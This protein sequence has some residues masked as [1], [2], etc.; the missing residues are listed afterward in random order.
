MPALNAL[1]DDFLAAL[2]SERNYSPHTV[3]AY[4]CDLEQ[5]ALWLERQALAFDAIGHRDMRHYLAELNRAGYARSTMNR[6]LSAIKAFYAWLTDE[7]VLDANP[8]SVVQGAKQPH[9]LPATLRPEDLDNLLVDHGDTPSEIRDFTI[10]E[11][12]YASGARISEVAG[13]TLKSIDFDAGS[14]RVL[15]KGSK[16]RV[17]P[18]YPH[19]LVLIRDYIRDVRPLLLAKAKAKADVAPT[20]ALFIGNSGKPLSADSLRKMFK[21]HMALIGGD[22]GLGPH[23]MRHTFAT[24]LLEGGADIRSVQ[25][26]LGH[27][28][29][30][31]T[32]IYTHI[33]IGHLKETHRK[34]HPRSQ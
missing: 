23:A 32:Q 7:N 34:A 16:E 15:G 21:R 28:S 13:L 33:S 17:I 1:I 20:Q 8:T 12:L 18:L 6:H 22:T 24:D 4:G 27:E 9:K 11:L 25:E 5:F 2:R 29:L 10:L 31:T 19:V 14:M 3:R 26:M 30:A